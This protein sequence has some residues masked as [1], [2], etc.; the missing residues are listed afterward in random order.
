MNLEFAQR[1]HRM[2]AS[3]I[4][5][6]LKVANQEGMIS[7]AG[8]IPAPST[9]PME[10][11][12]SLFDTALERWKERIFQ[13]DLSEGFLPLR[14]A[15]V[16]YLKTFGVESLAQNIF[17]TS[18]SQ[19]LLDAVGKVLIH[20]GDKVAVES[21]C[22][23]GALQAFRPYQPEFV[24]VKTDEWGTIPESLHKVLSQ[25]RPKFTYLVPTF[26]NPSGRTLP[27]QR[28]KAIAEILQNHEALLVEDDP[29]AALRY[30]GEPL[31]SIRSFAPQHVLY[32]TTLSKTFAPGLRLGLTVPPEGPMG[33][34]LGSWL[35]KAKQGT[36]LHTATLGQALAAVY[37]EEGHLERQLPKIISYYTPRLQAMLEA[38]EEHFPQDWTWS[39]P[40]GG[41]FVWAEGPDGT[42][43]DAISS[44]ALTQ[45]VAVVPGHHFHA[46]PENAPPSFRLNFTNAEPQQIKKAIAILAQCL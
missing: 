12:N 27:L 30:G 2:S 13:Y 44:Q 14:E 1:T 17:V 26:Q 22:Y 9:F 34:E 4:R 5:E 24:S 31:P 20:P 15:S 32:A 28:R 33:N 18:G 21:P 3:A 41:M 43:I 39:H 23:L 25:H 16:N 46:H 35:I 11:L 29:Y 45:G 36:D 10:I 19:G 8:G 37:L 7:L 42:N 6:I 38:L 40:E